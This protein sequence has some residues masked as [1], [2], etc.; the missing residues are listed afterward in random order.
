MV[1]SCGTAAAQVSGTNLLLAQVGNRPGLTPSNRQDLYD[2]VNLDAAFNQAHV[3]LRFETDRNSEQEFPYA[4]ITQRWV[5]WSDGPGRVRVGNYYTILGRGLL[6]RSFELPGVVLDAVGLRSR[7]AFARDMDGALAEVT[8]GPVHAQAFGGA[9]NP[10]ENSLAAEQLGIPRYLG[11]LSGAELTSRVGANARLGAAYL[12]TN[13]GLSPEE[14][15]GSGFVD[16]DPLGVF[17]VHA[18]SLPLY[19]EYAQADAS[20]GDWLRLRTGSTPH[21]LYASSGL[22]WRRLGLS[23]E[24]KD[25]AGFRKGTNDPPS[26]V[27]EQSYVLLNRN[28]HVLDAGKE[29]GYQFE[30]SYGLSDA[31]TATAN[32]SRADGNSLNRYREFFME[33]RLA[34]SER[35]A[36][37]GAVFYDQG[38][39]RT[40]A[41]DD[42][43]VAGATGGVRLRGDW[44][45]HFDL[46]HLRA[47]QTRGLLPP[48]PYTDLYAALV[49]ARA[50]RGSVAVTWDRTSDPLVRS[51]FGGGGAYLHL[52]NA[53]LGAQ[54]SPR[55]QATL[56]IGRSRGGRACTA[57]TCYEVPP[58]EGAE[59]RLVSRF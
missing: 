28:T 2:Q 53:V 51:V 16:V 55:Q 3:G 40:S 43:H 54:L 21:A 38:E 14:S 33:L 42:N 44:S 12:R 6:H 15:S 48:I 4:G 29:T 41:L 32:V 37:D 11:H 17:G 9:A 18:V 20:P 57:G 47:N 35:H 59:V 31:L 36:W 7:Y 25:Y 34:P 8:L 50:D 58:F 46:E 26:L 1:A 23:A 30:A 24:W 39:D 52:V 19:F 5:E 10:G 56:T 22:L 27:R 49:V 45:C 13:S